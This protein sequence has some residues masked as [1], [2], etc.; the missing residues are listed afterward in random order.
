MLFSSIIIGIVSYLYYFKNLLSSKVV[1]NLNFDLLSRQLYALPE[2]D[3]NQKVS[4]NDFFKSSFN[5]ISFLHGIASGDP[6]LDS[7]IFWTR[8]TPNDQV[9]PNQLIPIHFKLS[10]DENFTDILQDVQTFTNSLIDYTIKLDITGLNPNQ[11]YYYKF[12]NDLIS[13]DIGQTKTLP[14]PDQE[15]DVKLAVY[16][17]ANYAGGFYHAYKFPVLKN[18]VDYVIHLGDYIYEFANGVYTNGTK[19]GRDHIPEHEC[20]TLEDY[21]LRYALYRSDKDL[22]NSHAKFPWIL[23]WDDHEVA[24]NSWLRGSVAT[25]GYDFLKRRDE[26]TQAYFEWLPI[27]PQKNLSKIWRN[28]KFGKVFQINMLDTRHYSR[29]ITDYYHNQEFIKNLVEYED[30]TMLGYDQEEWL[31]RRLLDNDTTWNLIAS[32]CVVRDIDFSLPETGGLGFPFEE[33]NQDAWD[34]YIANRNRLL[35]FIKQNEL[36]N[37]VILSGDFHIAITSELSLPHEIY[38]V[39]TGEGTI[40]VEFTTS[41]VSSPTTFPKHFN[42]SQSLI[43]SKELVENN[44]LIWNDGYWRGYMELNINMNNVTTD[45]YGV[46]IKDVNFNNELHLAHFVVPKD[47]SFIDR[48]SMYVNSGAMNQKII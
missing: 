35:N 45:Y 20:E 2:D 39:E 15:D 16:S 48:E 25:S 9:D 5:N 44:D 26:A 34:G 37:N 6:T 1:T 36:K 12:Y 3:V 31:N 47:Q 17:C 38:N 22:Q 13:S 32:Q 43:M 19:L 7:I 29:D 41:A 28:F 46:D 4:T 21:R 8:I 10:S 27:R 14:Y 24:D 23:V 11:T 18:S 30:R 40:I 42:E 33:F